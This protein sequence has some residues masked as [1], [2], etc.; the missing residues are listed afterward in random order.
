MH[1]KVLDRRE[2]ENARPC[3]LLC[4]SLGLKGPTGK[5]QS[6]SRQW[7]DVHADM[8]RRDNIPV[9]AGQGDQCWKCTKEAGQVLWPVLRM[10]S[11]AFLTVTM[12]TTDVRGQCWGSMLGVKTSTGSTK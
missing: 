6:T 10:T 12:R 8:F 5:V 2:S 7:Y 1:R 9:E 3:K 4:A 11:W